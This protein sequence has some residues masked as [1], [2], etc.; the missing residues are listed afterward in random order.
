MS[1]NK[2]IP[3]T[4]LSGF[5]GAG[6][7]TL[8]NYWLKQA[9]KTEKPL[10][11]AIIVND[12]GAVNIDASLIKATVRDLKAPIGGM[13]ELTSGCI[14]CSIQGELLEALDTLARDTRPDHIVIEATGVAEPKS[15][16]QTLYGRDAAEALSF[17]AHAM[18][19][20]VD[21]GYFGKLTQTVQVLPQPRKWLLQSDRRRPLPELLFEQVECADLLVLNKSDLADAPTLQK[22]DCSLRDLNPRAQ[23]VVIRDGELPLDWLTRSPLFDIDATLSAARWRREIILHLESGAQ[24]TTKEFIQTQNQPCFTTAPTPNQHHHHEY[25]LETFLFAARQP[26]REA[27]FLKLMRQGFPGLLRAKGFFWTEARLDHVGLLSIAGD[28]LR[29]DYLGR[30]WQVLIE[31]GEAEMADLPELVLNAWDSK[32][33]DRRQELVFIGIDLNRRM[34]QD[35]LASCLI[36]S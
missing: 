9:A 8:L 3:I 22:L 17:H 6:K 34:L 11:L 26:F 7:T 25:G 13:V 18:V 14:C 23:R 32:T 29:A 16:L 19:T 10:R 35:Q 4:V 20:V 1:K 21:A 30:W 12:L 5:L 2:T 31:E 28:T 27:A 15:I 24:S 33:G 36:G